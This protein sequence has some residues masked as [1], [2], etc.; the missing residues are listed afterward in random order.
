MKGRFIVLEGIDGSGK[1]TLAKRL[2]ADAG[3]AWVTFEP[4]DGKI[5]SA[6]RSG[7]YGDIPPAAEALLFAADRS[8]HT[9]EIAKALDGGRWV[10]CDRYMGSTVAYQSASMGDSADWD[11]LVSMQKDAVI[12]P[13][14]VIL[15]D[16]DPEVSMSRVGNRGEE[17]SR[18]EKLEFQR[19]VRDAYLRLAQ[20]FGYIVIDASKD[21]DSVYEEAVSALKGRGLFASE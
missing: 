4:T 3:D 14:A 7:E 19:R 17:L 12:Q 18:F 20:M 11:W 9:A 13:D 21:A 6:L 15:L 1:T 10:I 5:G 8:I 2:A 16:M